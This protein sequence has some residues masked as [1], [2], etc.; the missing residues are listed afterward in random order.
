MSEWLV[1]KT[2]ATSYGSTTA[3]QP[4]ID[5]LRA[6]FEPD[7]PGNPV[8]PPRQDRGQGAG[9][10]HGS[11]RDSAGP[12]S[13]LDVPSTTTLGGVLGPPSATPTNDG[14]SQS[15]SS[16]R[17]SRV[18]PV[19]PHLRGPALDRLRDASVPRQPDRPPA[20]RADFSCSSTTDRNTATAGGA[21]LLRSASYRP[22]TARKRRRSSRHARRRRRRSCGPQAAADRSNT[23]QPLL[24]RGERPDPGR[25]RRSPRRARAPS[26]RQTPRRRSWSRPPFRRSW[27][28]GS[29]GSRPG[30]VAARVRVGHRGA[31]CPP[32]C[33]RRSPTCR[34]ARCGRA[35][36]AS[37]RPNSFTTSP[38]SRSP[39]TSSG[40]A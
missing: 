13:L 30:Q 36:L 1:L 27:R 24:S 26:S 18:Q 37:E 19:C 6:H 7:D 5:L 10:R 14:G 40:T 17:E 4:I 29:T 16:C 38:C 25:E 3:Y 15:R 31:V 35:S 22:A 8:G 2:G 20:D 34:R 33:S 39:R 9:T 32:A 28:R 12:L 11:R 21:D 23:R